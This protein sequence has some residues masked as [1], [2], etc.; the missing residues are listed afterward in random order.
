MKRTSLLFSL[1]LVTVLC[2]FHASDAY[3]EVGNDNFG[4]GEVL[5]Y[6]V[7]YGF[8]NAGEGVVK[9]SNQIHKVNNRPC[10][11]VT[12]FGRSVGAF[13]WV[14]RIRDTWKSYI[15]TSALLPHRFHTDVQEGKY[16]KQETVYFNHPSR[17]IRSEEK[18]NETKEFQMPPNVQD[19]LSGYCYM[20][21]IDFNRLN[22][23]DVMPI[24]AFF[25][26]KLYDFKIKYRGRDVVKTKFG[27]VRC[28][29]ITP[30]MPKNEMF[31]G[32]SSV[33]VWLT[34]D[35]NR[36]PVKVEADMFVGA[37]EMDLKDYKGL[38]H[39]IAFE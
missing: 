9:V 11:E 37:V 33:R 10:Y 12:A 14:I 3:R 23:G 20:R 29:R 22:I 16:R 28:I 15:D 2:G 32:E 6:R 19:I 38:R 1:L 31:D 36:I 8:I 27:K 21:T 17:T 26:D 5:E 18:N 34:D 30:V 24:P 4:P 25:D 13:D 7:H 39:K 35:K